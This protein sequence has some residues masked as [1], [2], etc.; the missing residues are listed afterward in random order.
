MTFGHGSSDFWFNTPDGVG[1]AIKTRLMLFAGE[2]FLDTSEGTR[3]GG[4]PLSDAVVNQ[5]QILGAH[6]QQTRDLAIK[7]RVLQ[8][9]GVSSIEDY[10]SSFGP[11]QRSFAVS[12][13]VSTIYGKLAIQAGQTLETG[14][15]L[16]VSP[17][18]GG[19]PL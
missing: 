10:S 3:W 2:W 11:D 17:I 7:L 14:F 12:M 1:Q 9:P 13:K 15:V 19:A 16:D 6:T 4:F 5:G 8:T 18:G